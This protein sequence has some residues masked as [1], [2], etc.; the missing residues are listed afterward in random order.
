[1]EQKERLDKMF[2][3]P[4]WIAIMQTNCFNN[5]F[6]N[7][8]QVSSLGSELARISELNI[9]IASNVARTLFETINIHTKLMNENLGGLTRIARETVSK[10]N[11]T[12]SSSLANPFE[13]LNDLAERVN[14]FN[15]LAEDF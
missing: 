2:S 4:S 15:S 7:L 3:T 9:G 10:L 6:T 1:M 8:N 5:H 13:H 12:L 11:Q 14:L